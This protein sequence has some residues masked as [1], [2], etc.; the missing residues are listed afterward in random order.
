MGGI[1]SHRT[2]CVPKCPGS[3]ATRVCF[4][5][6]DDALNEC[7]LQLI[8]PHA[9]ATLNTLYWNQLYSWWVNGSRFFLLT[10]VINYSVLALG[11][12]SL[13]RMTRGKKRRTDLFFW[14]RTFSFPFREEGRK[15]QA[16]NKGLVKKWP[17]RVQRQATQSGQC[18]ANTRT[19]QYEPTFHTWEPLGGATK[20]NRG[21]TDERVWK[22]I[23]KM[24]DTQRVSQA[25]LHERK[26]ARQS[27]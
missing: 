17:G 3:K 20:K 2:R 10:T 12:A 26:R 13:L 11:Q 9:E 23:L 14:F 25:E 7:V 15:P 16:G 24:Y 19:I 27:R 8:T 1:Q 18:V 6:D 21:N 4:C 22:L 5:I